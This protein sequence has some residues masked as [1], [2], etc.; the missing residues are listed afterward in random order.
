MIRRPPRS[1]LCQ[2]LFPYTTLFRSRNDT[3]AAALLTDCWL[4]TSSDGVAF[5]ETH[6]SR[7]FDLDLAPNA[8]GL[9][10]GDYEALSATATAFVPFY[11]QTDAGTAVA[12]DAFVSFPPASAAGAAAGAGAVV[13]F[14]ARPAPRTS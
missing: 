9:F 14:E 5:R 13:R 10:L 8:Q 12:S 6:L 3:S 1:T 4:V 7:P 2:T 11:V